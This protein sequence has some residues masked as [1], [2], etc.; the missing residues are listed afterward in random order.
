MRT[1]PPSYLPLFRSELQLRLLGLLVLHPGRAWTADQLTDTLDA[2]AASVHRELHRA[3]DAGLI[4]RDESLRPHRYQR[5]V[6][7]PLHDALREL[8]ARTVGLEEELRRVL[9]QSEGV[10]AAV[11]HGS[12]AG[13]QLRPGSDVD[14]LVVGDADLSSLRTAVRKAGRRAGR[15]VDLTV[16]RPDELRAGLRESNGFLTKI[17]EGPTKPLVGELE[18]LP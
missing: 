14:V 3:L 16:L 17:F 10:Q 11:I 4:E 6:E 13:G 8:L 18:P 2:P 9:G 1:K 5:A 15:E 12:W 7:S